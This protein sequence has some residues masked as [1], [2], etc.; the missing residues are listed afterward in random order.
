MYQIHDITKSPLPTQFDAAFSLDVIEHVPNNL[1]ND[2]MKNIADSL[3]N[4]A[5]AIIG[6]PNINAQEYASAGSKEGHINLKSAK[7]LRTLIEKY[8]QNVF[9][10]SM[11]DEVVHTGF[12]PMANYILGMGVGKKI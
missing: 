5:I 7:T 1:E 3:K 4:D 8:F 10:F 11:N 2:F 12:Y 6:T 9:I